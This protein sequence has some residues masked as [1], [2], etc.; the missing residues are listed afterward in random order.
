MLSL[1]PGI[2]MAFDTG[3]CFLL[4][5]VAFWLTRRRSAAARRARTVLAIG[6]LHTWYDYGNARP[7]RIARNSAVG[8][9]LVGAGILIADRVTSRNRGMAAMLVTF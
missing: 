3:L 9:I 6:T 5:S 4:F 7:G 1:F 2:P 8:F